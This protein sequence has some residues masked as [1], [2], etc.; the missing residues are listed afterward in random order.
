MNKYIISLIVLIFCLKVYSQERT[1]APVYKFD[2]IGKVLNQKDAPKFTYNEV[3][4]SWLEEK[5]H[6]F[7][8]KNIQFKKI[9]LNDSAYYVLIINSVTDGYRYPNI[10]QDYYVINRNKAL[11]FSEL[12]YNKI[13]K[14]SFGICEF[15][16]INNFENEKEL[17]YQVVYNIENQKKDGN[18]DRSNLFIAKRENENTVRFLLSSDCCFKKKDELKNYSISNSYFETSQEIF[19]SLIKF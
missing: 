10:K 11:I 15:E 1:K 2:K 7:D 18:I 13:S 4:K 19:S 5:K 3:N 9:I 6:P 14:Y 12:E 16:E 17:L 8:F